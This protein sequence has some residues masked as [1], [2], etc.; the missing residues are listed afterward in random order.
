MKNMKTKA[1][2]TIS[3]FLAVFLIFGAVNAQEQGN[4]FPASASGEEDQ[5]DIYSQLMKNITDLYAGGSSEG[6]EVINN[7]LSAPTGNMDDQIWVEITARIACRAETKGEYDESEFNE[8]KKPFD[9]SAQEYTAYHWQLIMMRMDSLDF[10]DLFQKLENRTIELEAND[11]EFEIDSFEAPASTSSISKCEDTDGE[12]YDKKGKVLLYNRIATTGDSSYWCNPCAYSDECA[13]QNVL[14]KY[15]FYDEKECSHGCVREKSFECPYG[16]YNGRCL[17]KEEASVQLCHG[18]CT[19][20]KCPFGTVNM[21]K[22]GCSIKEENCEKNASGEE[23]CEIKEHCCLPLEGTSTETE[24]NACPGNCLSDISCPEG[25]ENYG[26]E[27]C[28][29]LEECY[30]CGFLNLFT[31]CAY[32]PRLCCVGAS[33]LPAASEVCNGM[34]TAKLDCPPGW[35]N[36]GRSGCALQK[37]CE[38]CGFL[39]LKKCCEYVL[40]SCCVPKTTPGV[41]SGI[42]TI[43]DCPIG[44]EDVGVS[45]CG[46]QKQCKR[47][48]FLGLKKCCDKIQTKC[49]NPQNPVSSCEGGT[50]GTENSGRADCGVQEKCKKCGFL[51]LFKCCEKIP[52]SCCM[53]KSK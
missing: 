47:C 30:K 19:D 10:E 29:L 51:G 17:E 8:I 23:K 37:K 32:T 15:C 42:C 6:S 9:V 39:G 36:T 52:A 44:T 7:L 28:P 20:K 25:H 5:A 35:E 18:I 26:I 33:S 2:L 12:D 1:A 14:E 46:I 43:Y 50:E 24:Q 13:E 48:G 16:C 45:N 40:T 38:K 21:G 22:Q 41:C 3:L 31:C 4:P 49:C 53:L 27:G 11:C 34:C